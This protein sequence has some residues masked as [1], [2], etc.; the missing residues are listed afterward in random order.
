MTHNR[1]VAQPEAVAHGAHIV[2]RR[3]GKVAWNRQ[4]CERHIPAQ[5]VGTPSPLPVWNGDPDPTGGA[6]KND[7]HH[8]MKRGGR[9]PPERPLTKRKV[10][11]V[12]HDLDPIA[13][14]RATAEPE[15]KANVHRSIAK[16]VR[17]PLDE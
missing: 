10:R 6:S 11:L 2:C 7:R 9:R 17:H 14:T 3:N 12:H 15:T 4:P 5:C 16:R 8:S 1:T 13:A